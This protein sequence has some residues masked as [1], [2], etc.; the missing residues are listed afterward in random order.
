MN[1][2]SVHN[3]TNRSS[4][5]H[6]SSLPNHSLKYQGDESRREKKTEFQVNHSQQTT[7]KLAYRDLVT[8]ARINLNFHYAQ[9]L[10]T[11]LSLG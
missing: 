4:G 8:H 9:Q 10:K 7:V 1:K 3:I 2:Y 11:N 5:S 6:A